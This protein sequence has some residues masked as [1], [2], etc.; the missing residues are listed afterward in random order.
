M[1]AKKNKIYVIHDEILG[2]WSF[3]GLVQCLL[4]LLNSLKAIKNVNYDPSHTYL[5]VSYTTSWE[6]LSHNL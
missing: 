2:D 6:E 3:S 1:H 5:R 4:T